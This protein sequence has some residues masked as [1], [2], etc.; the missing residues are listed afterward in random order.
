MGAGVLPSHPP[1]YSE[2]SPV[3]EK[4]EKFNRRVSEWFSWI[5]IAAMLVMMAVT[6]IDVV[7]SKV[8]R[9]PLLGAIDI[10]MLVQIVA[11]ALLQ[12]WR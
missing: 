8:F 4:F 6:C 1:K 12:A 11:I 5:G 3:L 2:G 9:C 10:V 7:G